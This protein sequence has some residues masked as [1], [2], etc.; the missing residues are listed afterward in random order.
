MKNDSCGRGDFSECRKYDL[1]TFFVKLFSGVQ[2][3]V[4]LKVSGLRSQVS[5]VR[6]QVYIYIYIYIL[7]KYIAYLALKTMIVQNNI[8]HINTIGLAAAKTAANPMVCRGLILFCT[9]CFLGQLCYI[10]I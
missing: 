2:P 3:G 7:Y 6:S 1:L 5:G 10:F 4:Q 8:K 9:H